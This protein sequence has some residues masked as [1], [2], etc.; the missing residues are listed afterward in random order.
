MSC[1]HKLPQEGGKDDVVLT[2]DARGQQGSQTTLPEKDQSLGCQQR[3]IATII[4]NITSVSINSVIYHAGSFGSLIDQ[5]LQSKFKESDISSLFSQSPSLLDCHVE[6]LRKAF[7]FFHDEGFYPAEVCGILAEV[8]ELVSSDYAEATN[9]ILFLREFGYKERR[10]QQAVAECPQILYQK[11]DVICARLSNLSTIFVKADVQK[12][13]KG[14][15]S[16]L[17]EPAESLAE[18]MEYIYYD[19]GLREDAMV[20]ANAPQYSLSHIR[21]RHQILLRA[22]LYDKPNNRGISRRINPSL[23]DILGRT[24]TQFVKKV[25]GVTLEEYKVFESILDLESATGGHVMDGIRQD[26]SEVDSDSDDSD[27]DES[28]D[29]NVNN[30]Y[31]EIGEKPQKKVYAQKYPKPKRL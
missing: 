3:I 4:R 9:V 5:L 17:L 31:E 19:M 8:P 12:M 30:E 25:A 13:L 27:A 24:D 10:F 18:K 21:L 2:Q 11:P 1:C 7:E 15:L 14:G 28:D 29:N 23:S 20:E 22:G 26:D 6:A 16:L